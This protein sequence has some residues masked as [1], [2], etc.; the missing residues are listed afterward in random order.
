ME[1]VQ[2]S[3]KKKGGFYA[4]RCD[5]SSEITNGMKGRIMEPKFVPGKKED[6]YEK[7]IQR[8]VPSLN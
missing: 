2:A 7:F 1:V 5:Y 8:T 4:F 6:L 3:S